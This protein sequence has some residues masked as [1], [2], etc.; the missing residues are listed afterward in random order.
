M[1]FQIMLVL[2]LLLKNSKPMQTLLDFQLYINRAL[3]ITG[4][5][6]LS[7]I[8][9]TLNHKLGYIIIRLCIMFAVNLL[10]NYL[11]CHFYSIRDCL[12]FISGKQI[13]V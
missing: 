4:D 10:N 6:N 12:R 13:F 2:T 9:F 7:L 11:P 5:T 1:C 3:W 8:N